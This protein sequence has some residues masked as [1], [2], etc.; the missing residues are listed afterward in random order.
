MDYTHMYSHTYVDTY[1]VTSFRVILYSH[2][3]STIIVIYILNNIRVLHAFFFLQFYAIAL[4]S[5]KWRDLLRDTAY[6]DLIY[7]RQFLTR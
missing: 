3:Q 7:S 4:R 2:L 1:T 5:A 6:R